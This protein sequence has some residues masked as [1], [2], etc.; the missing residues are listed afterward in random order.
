MLKSTLPVQIATEVYLVETPAKGGKFACRHSRLLISRV[1]GTCRSGTYL[2]G[3]GVY[4][5]LRITSGLPVTRPQSLRG[6]SQ[7][8]PVSG[9][10]AGVQRQTTLV[11]ILGN[12]VARRAI[13]RR[14]APAATGIGTQQVL[15]ASASKA[16]MKM[17]SVISSG[18]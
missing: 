11:E 10:S 16:A 5:E 9:H 1:T 6:T 8:S 18:V 7:T 4:Q 15:Q 14:S 13:F 3:F 2:S 17:S 12:D